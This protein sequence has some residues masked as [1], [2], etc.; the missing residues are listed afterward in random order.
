[1]APSTSDVQPVHIVRS[2]GSVTGAK[3]LTDSGGHGATTLTMRPGAPAPTIIVDYG[4]DVGGV[5]YFVV[6]S[7]SRSPVLRVAYSEGAT[8]LGPSGDDTPSVSAAGDPDRVDKLTVSSPGRLSTGLIQ[9]G[10]RY[11]RITLASPG[12][13]TLSSIGIRFTAARVQ[14]H[15]YRGWFD[16]SSP[17]LNRIWFDGA[18]TTQLDELPAGTLPNPWSITAGSLDVHDGNVGI[19]DQGGHWTDYTMSFQTRVLNTDSGWLVRAT[20]SSSGYLFLLRPSGTLQEIAIGPAEFDVIADVSVPGDLTA[21]GWARVR[22]TVSGPVIT[23][24]LDGRQVATFDT[25]SLPSG[26]SVY[27]SGTVGFAGLGSQ[28]LFRDLVVTSS[29]GATLYANHLSQASALAGFT[30]PDIRTPDPLPL[31]MDGAKRDRV[32]WSGD[33]GVE[34]PNVFYTTATDSYVRGSLQLLASYQLADGESGTNIDPSY[35][36]GT[37]P[38][39]GPNYSASYSMDEVDNIATYYLYTG[40]LSF[41]R[42]E[43]PMIT[44]EMAY[45]Q[46]MVDSRGLLATDDSDGMDWDFYDGSKTGEV[47]AYNAIYYRTLED[48]SRL[49]DAL[50]LTSQAS[51]YN[52]AATN[53]GHA[54]NADLLDP[55]TGLYVLSNLEPAAVAQDANSLAVLFGIA[56]RSRDTTILAALARTLPSTPYGP[57][58][59]TANAGYRAGVSPF[60]THEEVDALFA[61]GDTSSATALLRTLWGYMDAPGPD[62]T[63]ADWELVGSHG[64]PGFGDFTSLAHGW[65]SGATADLS[66]YVLGVQPTTAGF[67]TWTVEP[68]PGALTWAE[69]DVP[70]PYGTID[71]RW[72]RDRSSGSSALQV[73]AP[74]GTR[75][76]VSLPVPRPGAVVTVRSTKHGRSG[77]SRR[78]TT[79]PGATSLAVSVTGGA[80][81]DLD[82]VPR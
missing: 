8:Y 40:D 35:P 56:P 65:S 63:G 69:G 15:D 17:L 16:S 74:S 11:E 29:E 45:N 77:R 9:G 19:L 44:R 18:Y 28:A 14:A 50:G 10:E 57:L 64:A 7:E 5:P 82:V 20:S 31:I 1:M 24:F 73:T 23:T 41:V 34:G 43:W 76:T 51:A 61:T 53:L 48:A 62:Y 36:L 2:S 54:I 22:T 79:P 3:A 55:S 6:T 37:F 12:T 70:T 80:V 33:L 72:A 68:H 25:D 60:V 47:T 13:L 32:V 42:S 66:S 71:V 75:G 67:R 49:A 81:Y 26:A 4:K 38:E 39:S 21:G 30:G 27:T 59:F 52:R 58:P 78:I 46:S